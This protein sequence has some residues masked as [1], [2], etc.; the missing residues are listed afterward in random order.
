MQHPTLSDTRLT[1]AITLLNEAHSIDC[2]LVDSAIE[3]M[4]AL[5]DELPAPRPEAV[6]A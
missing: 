3:L 2:P 5:C 4:E 1:R 6:A